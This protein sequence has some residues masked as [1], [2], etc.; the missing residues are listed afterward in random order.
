MKEKIFEIAKEDLPLY[1]QDFKNFWDE[2]TDQISDDDLFELYRATL[3]FKNWKLSFH[4]L[5]INKYDKILDEIYEDIN[6]SLF[7]AILGLYRSAHMHMRSSIELSMQLI[8][9]LHH[10]IEYK[11]WHDGD[12]VIKHNDLAEYI[13]K[14]PNFKIDIRNFVESITRNWR[15]L[16][17][18]IHAES[19]IFFQ[20]EK[21]IRKTNSFSVKDYGIWKTN[22]LRNIYRLNKLLLLFFKNDLSRFP[23]NSRN[24]LLSL[25]KSDDLSLIQEN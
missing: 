16:S 18:H 2:S 7:L 15:H 25:L 4:A 12:F 11:Q 17:K 8:Y 24:I 19:P 21:D 13:I 20:C 23:E 1:F 14:H 22:Y 10:P 6:S 9:F 5:D 3:V